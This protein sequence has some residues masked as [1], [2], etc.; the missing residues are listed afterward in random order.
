MLE[1]AKRRYFAKTAIPQQVK[2]INRQTA[3]PEQKSQFFFFNLS[4]CYPGCQRLFMRGFQ[5][6]SSLKKWTRTRVGLRPTKGSSPSHA[7]TQGILLYVCL[8]FLEWGRGA[9][10]DWEISFCFYF[11]FFKARSGGVGNAAP[12]VKNPSP[13]KRRVLIRGN[14]N[15]PTDIQVWYDKLIKEVRQNTGLS[16]KLE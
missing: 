1:Q 8:F 7:S 6:R 5:F 10:E 3:T 16:K 13:N 12:E 4:F 15:C 11:L 2:F 14:C 9:W